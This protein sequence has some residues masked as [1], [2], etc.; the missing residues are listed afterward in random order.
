MSAATVGI[1]GD[2]PAATG[3]LLRGLRPGAQDF[4]HAPSLGDATPGQVRLAR[5]KNF[6]DRADTVVAQMDRESFEKFARG[7]SI[8][9]MNLQPCVNLP[10]SL[11]HA[12]LRSNPTRSRLPPTK[13]VVL[14][15][16]ATSGAG[17][18]R[19]MGHAARRGMIRL[20][21]R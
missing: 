9:R 5:V 18:P 8:M 13:P 17:V 19:A 14:K 4:C 1:A 15:S 20:K 2:T 6:A 21:G 3:S 11:R 12:P 16:G 10:S 7:G